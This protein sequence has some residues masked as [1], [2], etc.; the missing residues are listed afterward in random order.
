MS[1]AELKATK[2]GLLLKIVQ[3]EPEKVGRALTV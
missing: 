3:E 2:S 1:E